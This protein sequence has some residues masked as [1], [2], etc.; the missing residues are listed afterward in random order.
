V[1][2]QNWSKDVCNL[3]TKRAYAYE[4]ATV[5]WIDGNIG[6]R[7]TMKYPSVYMLGRNAH[8]EIASFTFAGS[9]QHQDLGAKAVHLGQNTTSKI[10][11]KS[12]GKSSGRTTHRVLIHVGR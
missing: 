3:A 12:I 6:G 2:I 11:S 7:L 1:S 10:T 5:E 9:Q 4:D 8:T